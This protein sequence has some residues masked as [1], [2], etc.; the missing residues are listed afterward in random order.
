MKEAKATFQKITKLEENDAYF[1]QIHDAET[2]QKA[3]I[4]ASIAV[5]SLKFNQKKQF[6]VESKEGSSYPEVR[7]V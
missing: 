6:I 7:V 4:Q 1:N 3:A 5:M 2:L